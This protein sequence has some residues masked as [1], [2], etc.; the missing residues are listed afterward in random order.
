[1]LKLKEGQ[2]FIN[3]IDYLSHVIRPR[4]LDV[5]LQKIDAVQVLEQPT[6]FK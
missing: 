3:D 1:M 5:T 2:F 6:N 4:G